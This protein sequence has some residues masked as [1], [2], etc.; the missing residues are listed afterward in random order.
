[1]RRRSLLHRREC[2]LLISGQWGHI[3]SGITDHSTALPPV[4]S[5]SRIRQLSA[6]SLAASALTCPHLPVRRWGSS[7]SRIPSPRKLK[8]STARKK[9]GAHAAEARVPVAECAALS[10]WV[11][12]GHRPREPDHQGIRARVVGNRVHTD[13]IA[14]PR[15]VR[16]GRA[17]PAPIESWR[18]MRYHSPASGAPQRETPSGSRQQLHSVRSSP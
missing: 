9:P 17:N 7:T 2:F 5:G 14:A 10:Q 13:T 18:C 4:R 8:E 1:M 12:M 15:A 6:K 16:D 3:P 11:S